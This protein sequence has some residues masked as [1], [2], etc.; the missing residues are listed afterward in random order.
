MRKLII[1]VIGAFIFHGANSQ[2]IVIDPILAGVT[3]A[4]TIAE[5]E[6]YTKINDKQKA[7]E[8]LQTTTVATCNFIN[9]WHKKMYNGLQ[10]VSNTVKNAYQL[11]ECAELLKDIYQIESDM[12]SAA[13]SNPLALAFVMQMQ[14]D[15]V[16]KA[17]NYYT[18]IQTLILKEKDNKLLMD[19]G[20]RVNLLNEVR[21]NL[22]C[23]RAMAWC[24]KAKVKLVIMQGILQSINPFGSIV[25]ND[26]KIVKDI[27]KSW[28]Y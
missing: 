11:I 3:A 26:A 17:V 18:E 8:V 27:L 1:L 2:T 15:M 25:N 22:R 12:R 24:C 7:I 4:A 6:S 13:Q 16:T 28:K 10:Q 20:E 5:N 9:D 19:A 21:D 23:L 14:R